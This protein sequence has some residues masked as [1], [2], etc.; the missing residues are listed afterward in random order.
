MQD[1]TAPPPNEPGPRHPT[2]ADRLQA[3]L[4]AL[5]LT[6]YWRAPQSNTI[7]PI[8]A[9]AAAAFLQRFAVAPAAPP[10]AS[11]TPTSVD[12]AVSSIETVTHALMAAIQREP[13]RLLEVIQADTDAMGA[14]L[15]DL[16]QFTRLARA[17]LTAA[18]RASSLDNEARRDAA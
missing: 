1:P 18:M 17:T 12:E 3:Q 10:A 5:E 4:V 7:R 6:D 15:R 8:T 16:E 14:C 13:G 11:P 9:A 2:A